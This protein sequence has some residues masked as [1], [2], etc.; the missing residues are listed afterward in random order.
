MDGPKTI[1]PARTLEES[2]IVKLQGK[3]ILVT[4]AGSGIGR[5]ISLLL[6]QKGSRIF[7]VDKNQQ[8]LLELS[9]EAGVSKEMLS[10]QAVDVADAQAVAGLP[11]VILQQ[12]HELDGVIN[13]A[14][15]IQPFIKIQNLSNED[16]EKV[17]SVNFYGTLNMVRAL[18]PHLLERPE[19]HIVNI[20][21]MGGFLP[22]P[23][24][25]VYGASKAAVKLLTEGLYAELMQTNVH[26]T[27]V[28]PGATQTNIAQNSEVKV[29]VMTADNAGRFPMLTAER[30]A[31]I[32]AKGIEKNKPR[33]LTG[34]DAKVMS[35]LY[36][37]AP[38]YATKLIS[39]KM[40]ALLK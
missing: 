5:A 20:S 12:F 37:I 28:Y 18:L 30:A 19:A 24:Q 6:L 32:I 22:V 27:V 23:G 2:F 9:E 16:I 31:Q 14:G 11:A 13:C 1:T 3:T 35:I 26:V 29:P 38:V 25:S 34:K 15:I 8:S 36:R 10:V 17:M 39:K 21:S 4:G 7:A 33:I 40:Q